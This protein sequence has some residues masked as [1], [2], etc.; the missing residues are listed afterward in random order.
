MAATAG[1]TTGTKI[2]LGTVVKAA[3]GSWDV[4]RRLSHEITDE[5][6]MQYL[7]F[8][9]KP[10]ESDI[11]HSHQVTK[12]KKTWK[13][14]F[15]SKWLKQFPWLCYS[16]L[17]E[18]GICS[19]CILFPHKVTKG[20][21]PGVLVTAPYQKS[22]TK[23]LGKDGILNCHEQS[24]MHK[25]ATEQAD[26]FKQTFEN[27]DRCRVDS[28]LA[29]SVANQATENKEILRQIVLAVEFLAKQSLAFRGHRDDRV[30]FSSYE[31]NRGNF[32]AL[33]QLL[34]KGNDSL[35]KHLLS[36]SRQ[37]RY[38]SKTIQNDV[39]HV[40]ASKIKERLTEELRTKDL[41]FMIIADECTD[42]LSNQEILSLCLRFV[43]Q[44]T[45]NDP[46]V[47]ECLISFMHL[48]R[49]NAT[50]ISRKILESLSDPSISL[51][52]SNIR[53]QAYDG[54][55][56]MSSGKEGV[57][58]KIKETSPLALYTH[59]YAH[60]LNLSIAATCKLSEVRNLIG[61]INEAYL[62]LNNGPKRQQLFE[63]TLKEYLPENSHSKLPGLCKT[64]WVERHTCLDVFLEMYELLVTFLDAVIFP[65]EYP[66]LKSSTGSWNWDK[67][68]ITKAQGLKASL[69]SFQTVVVF[70]T[71]KNI[72]DEVKALASKLQ[73]QD[74]D[75][76]EAYTMVDEVIGNIKS[77]RKNI[78]IDFQVW[79]KEMLDLSEK[80]GIV[81]AIPRKTSIQRNRSNIPS[82][83]P[84]DHYKKSVAIPLLDSLIIQMQDRFSDED[85]HARHLLYLVPSIIVNNTQELSEAAKGM[86]FWENDLP[87]PKSLGNEL[88]RWQTMW[89]SAEKELPNNLLLALCAIDEDTFPNI[90]RLL[91][92]ACT[93]PISSA[94]AER[95]FSLMK[96][97]KTCTRSTMSE[98]RFSDLAV[99]A[100]HYPERFEVDEICDAFV[101]AHPRRLFQAT[102]FD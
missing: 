9:W 98:E 86:L 97:I 99:I 25:Y 66:H 60:C 94:E 48:E 88:R 64:R 27:P 55:S 54:A 63:L 29:T 1:S 65:H 67:D 38:T 85:R 83:S 28:Q 82:S 35:Q 47:K 10:S 24:V 79:Y 45:P 76:F 80:L 52:P 13:V 5:K 92:I 71:T 101:K 69:L 50:M 70:I 32:V 95:S 41:P 30:D 20:T 6:R 53:G 78:D 74:Q 46:H 40:Y 91:L 56:V 73:K 33:L 21:T 17:L 77:A 51:D 100:M 90:H 31:I 7:T 44:S 8:H 62:F 81:E 14:S 43:D 16:N 15:Q 89:Q 96:R 84:I 23:A 61:L 18:G 102:L 36:S 22:Y 12:G 3:E 4:L 26:L 2:D 59:C 57:Q 42:P 49:T 11:L 37:A 19:H 87:F 93:L 75:I 34:A 68:T 39:I 72:L 58:A